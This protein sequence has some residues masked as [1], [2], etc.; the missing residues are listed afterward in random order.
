MPS[1]L[2]SLRDSLL[3]AGWTA[4]SPSDLGPEAEQ[5]ARLERQD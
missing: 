2:T 4:T 5:M 1:T 3:A